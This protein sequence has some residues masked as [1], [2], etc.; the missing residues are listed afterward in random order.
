MDYKALYEQSQKELFGLQF[1]FNKKNKEHKERYVHLMNNKIRLEKENEE[2]KEKIICLEEDVMEPAP[3]PAPSPEKKKEPLPKLTEKQRE[4]LRS[5]ME[6]S[7]LI[8]AAAKRHRMQM[9]SRLRKG[10]SMKESLADI[11]KINLP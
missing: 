11:M 4:N 10:M 3:A 7:G 6:K 1:H 2:L 8:G 5:H 9:M